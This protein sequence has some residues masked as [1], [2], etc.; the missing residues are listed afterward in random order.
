VIDL[1]RLAAGGQG[2]LQPVVLVR[3]EQEALV[4]TRYSG[5]ETEKRVKRIATADGGRSWNAVEQT[6]L[7]NPDA[8]ITA[9]VLADGRL[10]A[11]LND[12]ENGRD[13]LSLKLSA[14]GGK[15]WRELRRLEEM[16]GLRGKPMDER[17]CLDLV[18][19]L[20]SSSD[21][22]LEHADAQQLAA[23]EESA[24]S[25][26]STGGGCHFEF[27]YPFMMQSRN[28]DIHIAYTWN[29]AFIKH[30]VFDAKWL[31]L[32]LQEQH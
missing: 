11:V 31:R 20:A 21:P 23:Y 30:V 10:L 2:T 19:S 26:V 13:S 29:R 17:A 12:E 3:S 16:S 27:S 22:K 4:L 28:G 25:L 8:A 5:K 24:K 9:Q 7:R 6:A 32:R 15:T 18:G 1:Q 14:D